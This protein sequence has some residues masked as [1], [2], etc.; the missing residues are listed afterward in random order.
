MTIEGVPFWEKDIEFLF[1]KMKDIGGPWSVYLNPMRDDM[2][3]VAQ[4]A[5]IKPYEGVYGL[6]GERRYPAVPQG[7]VSLGY[8]LPHDIAHELVDR[9]NAYDPDAL[10]TPPA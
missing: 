7:V 1:D 8:G 6:R 9:L 2:V 10:Q 4:E 5:V 3:F